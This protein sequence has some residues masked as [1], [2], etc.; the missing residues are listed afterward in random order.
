MII[1]FCSVSSVD[2]EEVMST[3]EI[4][5]AEIDRKSHVKHIENAV[6]PMNEIEKDKNVE[7]TM[8]EVEDDVNVEDD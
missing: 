4:L 7:E 8:N 3:I 6:E 5:K 1:F 2:M